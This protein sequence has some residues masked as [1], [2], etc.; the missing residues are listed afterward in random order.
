MSFSSTNC[1]GFVEHVSHSYKALQ[2]VTKIIALTCLILVPPK[3]GAKQEL[4]FYKV[5]LNI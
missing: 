4:L 3:A 1:G 5:W 2:S